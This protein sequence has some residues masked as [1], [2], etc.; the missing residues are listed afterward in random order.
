MNKK[1]NNRFVSQVFETSSETADWFGYYNYDTLNFD[2]TKML[3]NKSPVD[4]CAVEK[5]MEIELGY[6]DIPSG[7]WHRIGVSD[8]FNWQQG[9]MLQWLPGKGNENKVI[10]NFSKDNHFKSCIY[11]IAT[12][13]EKIID[14]P[15]Y[16]ITPDGKK[17]I[18]LNYERSYWCRAYHYSSVVN[19]EYNVQVAEDDGVFEVDL[20]NNTV[21]RIVDI[22]DVIN[23]DFEDSFSKAKHWLEHIMVSPDGSKFVFLHRFTLGVGY[24]TRICIANIDGSDLQVIGDWQKYDWSHFGWKGNSEFVIYTVESTN[25]TKSMVAPMMSASKPKKS[26]KSTLIS[27]IKKFVPK[28]IRAKAHKRCYQHYVLKNGK[29]VLDG[30]YSCSA[31]RIDGHPSFTEDE[32]YMVTDSYPFEDGFRHLIIYDTVTGKACVLAKLY[33]PLWGNPASCDLHPKLCKNN[34]YVAVDTAY[35]GKHR[36]ICFKIDWQK[37]KAALN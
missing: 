22:H 27:L 25:L 18:A 14:Y 3:C 34:D 17:A 19:P 30:E 35:T 9:A 20:E 7:T 12:G 10:Y 2:Q 33:A 13:E 16:C 21:R 5:G 8:S 26:L 4:G 11:D 32:R 28:R 15:I 29:F 6:Y 36:M 37:V 24:A 23:A 31:L 1:L